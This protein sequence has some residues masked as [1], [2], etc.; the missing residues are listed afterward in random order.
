MLKKS[1]RAVKS[2]VVILLGAILVGIILTV[3]LFLN[4]TQ[5]PTASASIQFTF[6]GAAEGIAP[7]GSKFGIDGI[8]GETVLTAALK[9]AGMDGRYTWDIIQ[10][11]LTVSGVY[12][13][14]IDKQTTSFD[15]LLDF[16]DSR[17]VTIKEF[18]PTQF[19]VSLNGKFDASIT[20]SELR[21]L[22]QSILTVYQETFV[23]DYS[24]GF[25][26]TQYAML[27]DIDSYDYPQ[28]LQTI[29]NDMRQIA[30]YAEELYDRNPTFRYDGYGFNDIYVRMYNL[31]DNDIVQ[32][33]ANLTINALTKDKTRLMMQYNC[34]LA[35]RKIEQEK[36]TEEL[37]L[38]DGLLKAYDK[39]EIIYLSTS[40]SLTKIDGNSSETYDALVA[41]R[42]SV[43]DELV[44]IR[45][46]IND[47]ILKIEDLSK[48]DVPDTSAGDETQDT[49]PVVSPT[50][51]D[52]DVNGAEKVSVLE[53]EIK[54]LLVEKAEVTDT[55]KNMIH[56]FNADKLNASSIQI[57]KARTGTRSIIS[58]AFAM[59]ALKTVGPICVVALIIC[60]L[61]LICEERKK[62]I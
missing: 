56:A 62:N 3:V 47:C 60:M 38:L 20:N 40:D 61:M 18:Y 4:E 26:D 28:M 16:N 53:S 34:E 29:Q 30:E 15:S 7:N 58:G 54:A 59:K 9:E 6:D 24:V 45:A 21:D 51:T 36:L 27:F 2:S 33:N 43:A 22:L 17:K 55:F 8:R 57:S 44:Q 25:D 19:S 32:L 41:R 13:E 12:P 35:D 37:R 14:D 11:S 10:P 39:N 49:V 23:G 5:V 1:S 31:I 48:L 50:V 52:E 42:R 46:K